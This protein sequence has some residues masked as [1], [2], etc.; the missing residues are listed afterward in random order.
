MKHA[1]EMGSGAMIYIPSR[2]KIDSGIRQLIHRQ[3]GD[4]I[5]PF[6]ESRLE[7]VSEK[8]KVMLSLQQAVEAHRVVRR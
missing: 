4:S 6:E 3:D 7:T 2:I 1:T 5:S 8:K